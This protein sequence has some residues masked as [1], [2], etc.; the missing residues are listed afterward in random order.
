MTEASEELDDLGGH[1]GQDHHHRRHGLRPD[2]ARRTTWCSTCSA[3]PGQQ[4]FWF[5]WDDLVRGAI[6][7]VVLVDTRRLDDS[8]PAL[9]YFESCGLPFVVAVNQFEGTPLLEPR[10]CGTPSPLP[11]ASGA[12]HATR[13]TA[14]RW[15]RSL[16]ALVATL[17][18]TRARTARRGG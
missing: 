5:M 17:W 6:G 7:A 18:P 11:R 1:A 14:S 13:G 3:R 2:H 8:F 15:S 16:T 12:D 10:T 9:D 4:R